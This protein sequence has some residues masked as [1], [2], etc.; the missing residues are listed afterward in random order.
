MLYLI[1]TTLIFHNF[2]AFHGVEHQNQMMHFLKNVA[3]M[4]GLLEFYAVGAGSLSVDAKLASRYT[5]FPF[6]PRAQRSI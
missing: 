3:I 1:P 2:W 5:A 4:G 6:W